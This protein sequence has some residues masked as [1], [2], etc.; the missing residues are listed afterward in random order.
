MLQW[1]KGAADGDDAQDS[2]GGFREEPG[3]GS[4]ALEGTRRASQELGVMEQSLP[5]FRKQQSWLEARAGL[6]RTQ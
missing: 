5:P 6:P 4:Q 3:M 2:S 1:G